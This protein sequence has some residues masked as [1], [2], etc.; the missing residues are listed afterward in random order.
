MSEQ[1]GWRN[2]LKRIKAE[3]PHW[4]SVLPTLPR[5]IDA[6]LMHDINQVTEL[7]IELNRLQAEHR[8][9]IRA[10]HLLITALLSAIVLAL[11]QMNK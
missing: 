3:A 5:K 10:F 11:W 2:V 1:I 4:G 9:Q 8:K 7:K 6:F